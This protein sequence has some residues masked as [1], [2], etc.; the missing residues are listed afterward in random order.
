MYMIHTQ[1][2]GHNK[3]TNTAKYKPH[4]TYLPWMA[5]M[6]FSP[7][8]ALLVTDENTIKVHMKVVVQT[9]YV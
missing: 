9:Y 2:M 3:P 4:R 7:K 8:L 1:G 6:A 5:V